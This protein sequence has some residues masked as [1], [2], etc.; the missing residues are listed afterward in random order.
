M[1]LSGI[2]MSGSQ[3]CLSNNSSP[4]ANFNSVGQGN[5]EGLPQPSGYVADTVGSMFSGVLVSG[6]G[7][8]GTSI[9][10]GDQCFYVGAG[11][12]NAVAASGGLI[13]GGDG[14]PVVTLESL[15]G[16]SYNSC[17]E[18]TE[19]NVSVPCQSLASSQISINGAE[20]NIVVLVG[21]R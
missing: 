9:G 19:D 16:S 8:S 4:P 14:T 5:N 13:F 6:V 11:A 10:I 3:N 12:R 20:Y 2:N 7:S 21:V 17:Q 18:C 1:G 15:G